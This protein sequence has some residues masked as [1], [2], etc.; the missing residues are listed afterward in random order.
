V[1]ASVREQTAAIAA[2]DREAFT[3]F[4]HEWFDHCLAEARRCTGRDESF[5]LD[6]VQETM[7]RVIRHI[8]PLDDEAALVAWLHATLRSACVDLLRKDLRRRR[9][10]QRALARRPTDS[11]GDRDDVNQETFNRI[12]WLRRELAALP[13]ESV[14]LLNMRFRLGWTLT[15]IASMVGV[16]P[17]AVDGRINRTLARLRSNAKDH[18]HD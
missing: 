14:R 9:R 7:L 2:G 6:A 3:R 8:K 13:P 12:D 11:D 16:K 18:D 10:E 1:T 17:G 15:R 4:Y 5:C